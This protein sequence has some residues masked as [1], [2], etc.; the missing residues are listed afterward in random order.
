MTYTAENIPDQAGRTI[1]ITGANTGLGFASAQHF[2]EHGASEVILA[3]RSEQRAKDAKDRLDALKCN[4]KVR[5]ELVDMADLDDVADLGKRL[6]TLPRLDVLMLNAGVM[7]PPYTK[8]KQGHEL[9]MAVNHL[10]GYVLTME[11][12]PLLKKT[13]GSRIVV[14]ASA[15]HKFS[16]GIDVANFLDQGK[17]LKADADTEHAIEQKSIQFFL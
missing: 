2:L 8:S 10:A 6:S 14:V 16:R 12:L 7:V 15:A 3:C 11:T 1:V 5:I 13:E 4:G 9:M 17:V